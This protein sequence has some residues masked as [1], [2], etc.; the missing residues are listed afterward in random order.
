MSDA[1]MESMSANQRNDCR[2]GYNPKLVEGLKE[3]EN[4]WTTTFGRAAHDTAA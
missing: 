2:W 3:A 4:A 1:D